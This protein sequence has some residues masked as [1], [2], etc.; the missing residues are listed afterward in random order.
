MSRP[1]GSCELSREVSM[2]DLPCLF[3]ACNKGDLIT[4]MKHASLNFPGPKVSRNGSSAL[5][6][7]CCRGHTD[8]VRVL[9]DSQ[10]F[11]VNLRNRSGYSPLSA[12]CREHHMVI[13][14]LLLNDPHINVNSIL[15]ADKPLNSYCSDEAIISMLQDE[16]FDINRKYPLLYRP[17]YLQPHERYLPPHKQTIQCFK[18]SLLYYAVHHGNNTMFKAIMKHPN[19]NPNIGQRGVFSYSNIHHP[20]ILAAIQEKSPS[21]H[22][23]KKDLGM[24]QALVDHPKLLPN[25][26]NEDEETLIHQL[27]KIYTSD[28]NIYEMLTRWPEINIHIPDDCGRTVLWLCD[29]R[30]TESIIRLTVA[31][32][33]K[34]MSKVIHELAKTLKG[35]HQRQYLRRQFDNANAIQTRRADWSNSTLKYAIGYVTHD[36]KSLIHTFIY[37]KD[38]PYWDKKVEDASKHLAV[39]DYHLGQMLYTYEITRQKKLPHEMFKEIFKWLRANPKRK[40]YY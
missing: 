38:A 11:D 6:I 13:F 19:F 26:W 28:D 36:M 4:V 5:Y 2:C 27:I 24:F 22:K 8:I 30:W 9:L 14:R 1:L 34:N 21:S 37:E 12:A 18:T 17:K 31:C 35:E 40:E 32:F 15:I 33:F 39:P 3:R 10:Q 16:S 29:K 25:S 7:A 23:I 20:F